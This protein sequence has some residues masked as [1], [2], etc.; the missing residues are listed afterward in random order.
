MISYF[1]GRSKYIDT[2]TRIVLPI[3]LELAEAHN[4]LRHA[5]QLCYHACHNRETHHPSDLEDHLLTLIGR[6]VLNIVLQYKKWPFATTNQETVL[7]AAAQICTL[8][9]D[10]TNYNKQAS[11]L[12]I[13]LR[14]IHQEPITTPRT[15]TPGWN[16]EKLTPFEL[17]TITHDDKY[18]GI[19]ATKNAARRVL[20]C[21]DNPKV[22]AHLE[23]YKHDRV[24]TLTYLSQL[25]QQDH[26][27]NYP[28]AAPIEKVKVNKQ[29]RIKIQTPLETGYTKA[30]GSYFLASSV[31]H[32]ILCAGDLSI[33]IEESK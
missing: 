33:F 20:S 18:I 24:E 4:T 27:I 9:K 6:D 3:T 1:R 11:K 30:Y 32:T 26:K 5:Q 22:A 2:Q 29:Y 25:Y 12:R 13:A 15:S 8:Q 7:K 23:S 10:T 19:Y 28:I 17:W 14:S 31:K 21:V 16:I